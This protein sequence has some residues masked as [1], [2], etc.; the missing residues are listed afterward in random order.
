[1]SI[2]ISSTLPASPVAVASPSTRAAAAQPVRQPANASAD[3]VRLSESQQ[4]YQ[5]YNQGQAVSQIASSLSLTVDA[6][7]SYL[8]LRARQ[9]KILR[10][11][12]SGFRQKAPARKV[13]ALTPSK[14]LKLSPAGPMVLHAPSV[15]EP[16]RQA[17]DKLRSLPA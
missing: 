9:G 15:W 10:K 5:L 7:N 13:R 3:T 16:L 14:P 8:G 12:R 4:V 6:V 1:M 2:S 11:E 17:Q